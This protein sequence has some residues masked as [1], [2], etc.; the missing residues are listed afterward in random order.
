MKNNDA[1]FGSK[2]LHMLFFLHDTYV[3]DKTGHKHYSEKSVCLCV[4][5]I[6]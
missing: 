4:L 1:P 3:L 5:Y 6:S 2:L